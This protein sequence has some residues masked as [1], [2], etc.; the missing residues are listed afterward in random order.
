MPRQGPRP[1]CWKVQGDIP[2]K[3]HLA[4]LQMRAQAN[5]RKEVFE[6]TFE[7]FQYLWR[8]HWDMKGRA[9]DDYCLTRKDPEGSWDKHNTIC[10]P[11]IE[12]L[13]RQKTFKQDKK[14]GKHITGQ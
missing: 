8:D 2:H 5:Y 1:H 3:Q 12:H 6:L 7:D 9:I 11:R 13:R 10:L 4:F 14:N